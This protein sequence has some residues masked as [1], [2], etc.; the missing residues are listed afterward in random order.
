[1]KE[2]A[3]V[4]LIATTARTAAAFA[5]WQPRSEREVLSLLDTLDP[6]PVL[7]AG[8][9][10]FFRQ[11]NAGLDPRAVIELRHVADFDAVLE[12]GTQVCIG[13]G[14]THGHGVQHA[15]L[16][17]R[18]PGLVRAWGRIATPRIRHRATLGGNVMAR[19]PRYEMPILLA[20]LG[21][22]LRLWE[23]GQWRERSVGEQLTRPESARVL[24]RDIRIDCAHHLYLGYDR[25]LRPTVTVAVAL[26][27][28]AAGVDGRAVVGIQS[29]HPVTLPLPTPMGQTQLRA[30][31]LAIAREMAR[32]L[33]P[34][35][36]D[37]YASP[38][39]VQH[40][41]A[42]LIARQF[43]AASQEVTS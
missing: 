2:V 13:S 8:G 38:A 21:A 12:R 35:F 28:H 30:E 15:L 3:H 1:M 17:Q 19:Q 16:R 29:L 42:T 36:G 11:I 14:V 24:L 5:V 31:A 22:R 25:S 40:V 34:T 39:F 43:Q 26:E 7:L 37:A 4:G 41:A 33:P 18:L 23:D 10:D 6:A 20:A 32:A 9:T 27:R